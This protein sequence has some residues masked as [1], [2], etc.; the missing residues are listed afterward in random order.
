MQHYSDQLAYY[1]DLTPEERRTVD[2]HLAECAE[3]QALLAQYERQDVAL[4]AI[5]EIRPR[6]VWRP[7]I[8]GVGRRALAR[9]GDGLAL[10][11]LGALI[12]LF[13][14]Q[15]QVV[16]Q[17]GG[18]FAPA[19]LEPGITLPPTRL[20]PPSPWLPALPWLAGSLLAVGLLFV[21]TRKSFLPTAVGVVVAALLL[22]SFVPPFS[23]LPN[24]AGLYWRVAG[25]YY[26]DPR[27]PF[28]NNFLIAGDPVNTLRPYLDQLIGLKGLTPLDPNS[29]LERYEIVRVG[30]HPVH[31]NVTLVNVRFVYANG[32]SRVYPVPLLVPVVNVMGLWQAGWLDDGLQRLRSVHLDFPNQPFARE[33]DPIT[34]G[35]VERL[36]LHP[37]AN[38]LDEANP[39]HWLWESVR[40]ERLVA[41][42][43][44]TGFLVAIEL[45]TARR[46]LWFVPFSG[47]SPQAIGA[48][49]DVREY[50]FSPDARF[51]VYT[52]FDPEAA[53]VNPMR[54]FAIAVAAREEN[55]RSAARSELEGYYTDNLV[56]G[57]TTEQL[58]GLTSEGVW[59][60]S[61]GALW[62]APYG[63]GAPERL[64]E[65]VSAAIA[66]RPTPDGARVV[67]GCG[68]ALC[69]FEVQNGQALNRR[70]ILFGVGE[71]QLAW[72]PDGAQLAVIDRDPNN[73][74]GVQLR[75]LALDGAETLNVEI[76]PRDVTDPPQWTP[77]GQAIF[78]QTFPQEGRRIIAVDVP[79]ARVLD[80]SQPRWDAYFTL[81]PDGRS[82]LLNNGR[83][84][85]WRV[86]V[87]FNR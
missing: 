56:T 70:E 22:T 61:E 41:A 77:D 43:D 63:N 76:A 55:S 6:R 7:T 4:R 11:G 59:F 39:G 78:V 60:V 81:L 30:L 18:Q 24:P 44:S 73:L 13:A 80:L 65:R 49:G 8:Q 34:L 82:L 23:L 36:D 72:S 47:E 21:F 17:G 3:C 57:L 68:G 46:Q 28:K 10:A 16:A 87:N 19:A 32:T 62:R 50:G 79:A 27:L 37:Q 75:V 67:V 51:I 53:S 54:P 15:V 74:R 29:A 12:W 25:G 26:Y 48:P 42:P 84:D 45:D 64:L 52:R 2:A 58:P 9:L 20:A 40:V 31:N 66:P 14:L 5:R 1:R 85:F 33:G 69:L 83:G 38:R 86:E 35:N 71:A